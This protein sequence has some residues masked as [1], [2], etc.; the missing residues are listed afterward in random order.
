MSISPHLLVLASH[1]IVA[2]VNGTKRFVFECIKYKR[3]IH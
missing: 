3:D 2:P 1:H